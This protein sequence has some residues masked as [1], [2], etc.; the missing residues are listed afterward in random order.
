MTQKT[1]NNFDILILTTLSKIIKFENLSTEK[2]IDILHILKS[3]LLEKSSLQTTPNILQITEQL[4]PKLNWNQKINGILC[5]LIFALFKQINNEED[6][7]I[8]KKQKLLFILETYLSYTTEPLISEQCE[9]ILFI[10]KELIKHKNDIL[11]FQLNKLIN[12]ISNHINKT[13]KNSHITATI[14]TI[15]L[16]LG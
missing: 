14:N 9:M 10:I 13:E 2:T 5:T 7:S 8:D 4:I 12:A 16:S 1:K 3:S 15:K 6:I 11:T